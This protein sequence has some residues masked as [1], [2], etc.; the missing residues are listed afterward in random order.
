MPGETKLDP[1]STPDEQLWKQ[2]L[3][4]IWSKENLKQLSN[5]LFFK[6]FPMVSTSVVFPNCPNGFHQPP[7]ATLRTK[8]RW[9]AEP[10][11]LNESQDE[12]EDHVLVE[13]FHQFFEQMVLIVPSLTK[14]TGDFFPED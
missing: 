2:Q 4:Q 1:C 14:R 7:T 12:D 3:S 11:G 8:T 6:W 5:V 10:H 13:T 9:F